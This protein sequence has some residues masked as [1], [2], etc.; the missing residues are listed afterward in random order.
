MR[1][2]A[3]IG[4]AVALVAAIVWY[5]QRENS[6]AC[7]VCMRF[8]GR[9]ACNTSTSS[10]RD[11]AVQQATTSACARISGGVTESIRCERTRP[12]S[13]TCTP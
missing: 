2:I 13:L 10:E 8:S 4:F 1:S 5:A 9:Q 7:E 12:A 11:S 6:V 3:G